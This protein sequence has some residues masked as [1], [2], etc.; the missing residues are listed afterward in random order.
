[1]SLMPTYTQRKRSL[2]KA[3]TFRSIVL[4]SDFLIVYLITH[5]VDTSLGLVIMTNLASTT[6][7]YLHERFWTGI[8]W[9]RAP[10]HCH[11][12]VKIPE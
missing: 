3:I 11:E 12:P 8:K 4:V 1:M 7:Y 9:G 5:R 2:V 6:L 10:D